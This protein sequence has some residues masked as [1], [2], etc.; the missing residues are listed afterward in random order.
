ML[1]GR[2]KKKGRRLKKR[3]ENKNQSVV[4]QKSDSED[5]EIKYNSCIE[6]LTEKDQKQNNWIICLLENNLNFIWNIVFLAA[7]SVIYG[8]Y[9]DEHILFYIIFTAITFV[10]FVL[11]YRKIK[12]RNESNNS[13]KKINEKYNSFKEYIREHQ[14]NCCINCF[15]ELLSK[16]ELDLNTSFL[17]IT[18]NVSQNQKEIQ[19]LRKNYKYAKQQIEIQQLNLIN[20]FESYMSELQSTIE[21]QNESNQPKQKILTEIKTLCN[22]VDNSYRMI[23]NMALDAQHDYS[24]I[25]NLNEEVEVLKKN[26]G[27]EKYKKKFDE[28][29]NKIEFSKDSLKYEQYYSEFRNFSECYSNELKN[30]KIEL[31]QLLE[32]FSATKES[33]LANDVKKRA[34]KIK[35]ENGLEIFKLPVNKIYESKQHQYRHFSFGSE[36]YY[37]K[38]NKFVMMTGQTGSGKT[39]MVNNIVNYVYGINFNDGFRFQIVFEEEEISDRHPNENNNSTTASMTRWITSYTL[40]YEEGFRIPFNLVIIDTP[41]LGDTRGI[42]YDDFIHKIYKEFFSDKIYPISE[43]SSIGFVV[44]A[45]DSK[46]NDEQKYIF[47]AV[48]NIFGNNVQNNI[49]L[50]FTYADAQPPPALNAIKNENVPYAKEA[51]FKFNNSALYS[52]RDDKSNLYFWEAG[53][54]NLEKFFLHVKTVQPASL[55]LTKIVLKERENLHIYLDNVQ[56]II[57]DQFETLA[58]MENVSKVVLELKGTM[59][60]NKDF[61]VKKTI[62]PQS[63]KIVDHYITNCV[64]CHYT[65][66]DPC[67]I[68]GDGKQDCASMKN[69]NCVVCPGKCSSSSH[70]NG[71]RIYVYTKVEVVETIEDMMN[72]YKIALNDE[73]AKKKILQKQL[74]DYIK[75]KKRLYKKI[76]KAGL[77]TKKLE[78]ISIKRSYLNSVTYIERLIESEWKSNRPN[79]LDRIKQ[80]EHFKERAKLLNKMQKDPEMNDFWTMSEYETSVMNGIKQLDIIYNNSK[81][82][83]SDKSSVD[84]NDSNNIWKKKFW[85]GM[86]DKFFGWIDN[87]EPTQFES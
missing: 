56:K 22:D 2:R 26:L 41:G 45:S 80:L 84:I 36:N 4:S 13:I 5:A 15:S 25:K 59:K 75:L 81:N 62:Y 51:V 18:N 53:I 33:K 16:I 24:Y 40:Y 78:E 73:Q 44:K 31:T 12:R 54:T 69:G 37:D 39:L 83:M 76:Y 71:D 1:V 70:R 63:T 27:F 19:L 11:A 74:D 60:S 34:V 7:I 42:N 35:D 86:K 79:K 20:E 57:H 48:L 61:K 68:K 3:T 82:S 17:K 50:L 72:R 46:V 29:Y 64:A 77:A 55:V 85:I 65:C 14:K 66:H 32:Q 52:S 23:L 9:S 47:N 28:V 67:S 58:S 10:L 49:S 21:K 8:N 38:P 87:A 43:L 30:R 6:N